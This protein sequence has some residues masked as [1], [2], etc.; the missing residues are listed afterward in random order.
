M[1]GQNRISTVTSDELMPVNEAHC[2]I[3]T[4]SVTHHDRMVVHAQP[5][6][7]GAGDAAC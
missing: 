5:C 4:E 3:A 7:Q 2:I 1:I 6:M